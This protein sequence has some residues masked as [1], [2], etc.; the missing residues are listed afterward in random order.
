V[1]AAKRKGDVA[2]LMVAADLTLRGFQVAFLYGEDWDF[3]LALCRDGVR[4]ERV[5]VKYACSDGRV[6]SVRCRS[7]SLTNGKVRAT[8]H[9]SAETIDW[10]AVWD[11]TSRR[12][13]YVPASELGDGMSELRLRLDPARN[14]QSRGI[15][16]AERYAEL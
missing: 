5:Q 7:Q 8:K 9:Y 15:R 12:C 4:F 6:I 13:F 2:E 10:L 11:E 14:G 3:D 16:W 1:G